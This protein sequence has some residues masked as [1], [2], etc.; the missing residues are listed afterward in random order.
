MKTPRRADGSRRRGGE[1]R[2]KIEA[3]AGVLFAACGYQ[4]ATM[5][6]IADEAG[7]HVQTIYL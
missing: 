2:R 6:A 7:V 3:A 4:A 1:T 5:Q